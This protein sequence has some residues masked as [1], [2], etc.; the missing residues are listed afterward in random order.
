MAI[1]TVFRCVQLL[2]EGVAKLHLQYLRRNG[3]VFSEAVGTDI[4]YL[5]SVRPD[6]TMNVFDF[7]KKAVQDMLLTGN[8]Y[9][10]PVYN[11]ASM[12]LE[13]LVLCSRGSVA[14]D[15]YSDTYTITDTLNGLYGTYG[16]NDI[17]HL[18]N[19]TLDGKQGL[20]TLYSA[21]MVLNIASTGD[22]ET[23]DRFANGGNVRG[24][25]GNAGTGLRGVGEFQ[26]S[27]LEGLA[28]DLDAQFR[29]GKR[30][31]SMPSDVHWSPLSLSS[32]DMQFLDSRKF[33]I[34]EICRFFGVNPVYVFDETGS[35]NYK[36]AANRETLYNNGTL[37]PILS[38]IEAE[39]NAKLIGRDRYLT[40][41]FQFDRDA[42]GA[43]DHS[44][45][46]QH[47]KQ[48]LEIGCTANEIRA[49]FNLAPIAGGD[50]PFVTA[51]LKSLTEMNPNN[52]NPE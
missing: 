17:V 52:V 8:A 36:D 19:Y 48:L 31:V 4:H 37:D 25:V 40:E 16:E 13:R 35:S 34:R 10:V 51:N 3:D 39:F 49:M 27:E 44:T 30:I 29:S 33:T 47:A 38:K 22:R 18:K 2:S 26:D 28:T 32:T 7:W 23:L 6:V 14:H 24:I 12:A 45:R 1:A 20:S 9:I 43:C 42:I 11:P 15:I 50:V 41:K 5:L 21:S 46:L